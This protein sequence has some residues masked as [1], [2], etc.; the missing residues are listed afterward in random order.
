MDPF[1]TVLLESMSSASFVRAVQRGGH[2]TSQVSLAGPVAQLTCV[3]SL[4]LSHLH[5]GQPAKGPA[6]H[7][8]EMLAGV[9]PREVL[10]E[11]SL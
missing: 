1:G 8:A 11:I 9:S 2:S 3:I 10:A 6:R 5:L 7:M 4:L